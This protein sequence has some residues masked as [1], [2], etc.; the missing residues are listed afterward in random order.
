MQATD[1]AGHQT[2]TVLRRARKH[3]A[4]DLQAR[5]LD[6]ALTKF[7]SKAI[8]HQDALLAETN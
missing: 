7:G 8:D 5:N 1:A 6:A 3:S 2:L 4:N